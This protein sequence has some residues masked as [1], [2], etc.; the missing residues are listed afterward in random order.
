M[1]GSNLTQAAVIAGG[2]LLDGVHLGR[3]RV[4]GQLEGRRAQRACAAL[5]PGLHQGVRDKYVPTLNKGK[6]VFNCFQS[7]NPKSEPGLPAAGRHARP[8]LSGGGRGTGE[9]RRG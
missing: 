3:P 7:I 5:L 9:G 6:N 1:A 2:Q 4:A 8:R